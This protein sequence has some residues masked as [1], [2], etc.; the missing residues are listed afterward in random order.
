MACLP[1]L[2]ACQRHTPSSLAAVTGLSNNDVTFFTFLASLTSVPLR[3]LRCVALDGNPAWVFWC[4]TV[5]WRKC[6]FCW[7]AAYR[8]FMLCP[9]L[10]T[11]A[12]IK[13][14]VRLKFDLADDAKVSGSRAITRD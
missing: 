10:F 7:Q 9:A 12:H 13:K 6:G 5:W 8:H 14:F 4:R 1:Q 2:A 11:V 3:F